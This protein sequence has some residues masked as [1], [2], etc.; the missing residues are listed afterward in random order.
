MTLTKDDIETIRAEIQNGLKP[1]Q[2]QIASAKDEILRAF[3]MTEENIRQD[4]V[5]PDELAATNQRVDRIEQQLGIT[6]TA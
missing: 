2:G 5:H 3:Q 6:S 1:L 4:A